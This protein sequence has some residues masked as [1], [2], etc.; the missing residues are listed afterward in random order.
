MAQASRDQ[1]SVPT[2][3][4]VSSVDG[5]TPVVVYADPVTHRLLVDSAAASGTVTSVSVVTANGFAGSVADPTTTPAI[6]LST[7]V[8]GIVKGNGTA[9]SAAV[10]NTDYQVPITLTTTGTTG[11]ATFNGTT[12]NI[13]IYSGAG[14]VVGPASS[15]DNAITRFDGTTG[16]LVQ[17]ST[18]TIGDDGKLTI[19]NSTGAIVAFQWIGNDAR[20]GTINLNGGLVQLQNGT[21]QNTRDTSGGG[22]ERFSAYNG[23]TVTSYF[24]LYD[25][26]V[27]DVMALR[28]TTNANVFRVYNTY[29]SSGTNYER[30][31]LDWQTSANVL[32]VGAQAA[33]TGTLRVVALVGAS[34]TV[35]ANLNPAT[36]DGAALGTTALQFS[37][38]FLAEGGVINWDNGD[39]TLTQVGDVVTLAGA[40]LKVSSPGNVSTSVITTDGTQTLT[41]KTIS[42]TVEPGTDD[43][44][45]GENMTGLN[46]GDTI[47]Q[48]DAVYLDSSS[49]RWEFTD[50]DAAA[51][52][53][54][55]LVGLAAAA[56]TDGNPLTVVLRGVIRNDGWTWTT[57]GAPLYLST[58]PGAITQTAPSGTD[59]VIR[60]VGYVLSDDCI[61]FNP[62]NDW[63]THT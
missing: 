27:A 47:A 53:G 20:T 30:G 24:Q 49:G 23:N 4:A 1:N 43:T 9:L 46:A 36:N 62:S 11:A 13:P 32:T 39:A 17:N 48:W 63:I 54:G 2:L 12:L 16:K 33:G 18:A 28:R 52:A 57:V 60:V 29:S 51:T 8:T 14:Y 44:Y 41:N 38:L 26:G 3:L 59:D 31:V 42:H 45:T 19:T 22:L 25:D 56:G 58:S 7:T 34:I 15:T 10:A 21:Y 6:T 40:D 37:D 50:A 5:V 55:V 61:Y 35:S